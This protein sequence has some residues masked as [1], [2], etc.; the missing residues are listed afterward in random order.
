MH[1]LVVDED[2]E[3]EWREHTALGDTSSGRD[4]VG[5]ES[6][7]GHAEASCAKELPQPLPSLANDSSLSIQLKEQVI[8]RD[9]VKSFD[10]VKEEYRQPLVAMKRVVHG[11]QQ[12]IDVIVGG[13][14][15]AKAGL[16]YRE[17]AG[18]VAV[19]TKTIVD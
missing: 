5:A 8:M 6:A 2:R 7:I 10:N 14:A 12:L 19:I 13:E 15:F 16:S 3:E 17:E 11:L 4:P 9:A 18:G 1:H